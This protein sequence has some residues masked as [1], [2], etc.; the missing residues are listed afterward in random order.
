[1]KNLIIAIAVVLVVITGALVFTSKKAESE[2]VYNLAEQINYQ[3]VFDL[4]KGTQIVYYYQPTCSHCEDFKPTL[5]K[6]YKQIEETQGVDLMLVN[7]ADTENKAVFMASDDPKYTENV[8]EL[9]E[10]GEV[11]IMGT[12]T[13]IKVV[14]GQ[15]EMFGVGSTAI[16][17]IFDSAL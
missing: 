3:D 7:A 15:V 16:S 17:A 11:H 2:D 10:K 1:M 8:D 4:G 5:T 13:A 9:N 14:D 12:P 6:Y